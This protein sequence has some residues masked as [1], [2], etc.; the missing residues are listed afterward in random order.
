MRLML[1]IELHTGEIPNVFAR[2]KSIIGDRHW[3]KRVADFKSDIRGNRFLA[4]YLEEENAIAFA[5]SKCSDLVEK[6]GYIPTQET[7]LYPALG[8]AAQALSIIDA[9]APQQ[10]KQMI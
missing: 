4:E 10:A 5:L 2:F 6:H 1:G 3:R 9:S 7:W 8:F